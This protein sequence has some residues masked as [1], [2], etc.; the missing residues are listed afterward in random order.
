MEKEIEKKNGLL[1]SKILV[2]IVEV[3]RLW[4]RFQ[5]LGCTEE[6]ELRPDVLDRPPASTD[7]FVKNVRI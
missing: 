2:A 6:G 1:V 5:Q 4:H 3:E 7:I